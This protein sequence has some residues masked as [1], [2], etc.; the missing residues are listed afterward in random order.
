[1]STYES[2]PDAPVLNMPTRPMYWSLRRELWENRSLYMAPLLVAAVCMFGFVISTI[3]MPHRRRATMLLDPAHRSAA[4]AQPYNA[5]AMML[6]FASFIVA[7]F[8][9]IDALY[10]ERRDRSILFW[11]SLPVSDRTTV[12]AKAIVPM[13]ILPAITFATIVLVQFCMLMWSTLI[14]LPSGQGLTTWSGFNIFEESL[15][16]LYCMIAMALWYAP[17]YG[18]FLLVSGWAKRATFLWAILPIFA[19]GILDQ[20]LFHGTHFAATMKYRL[21][22]FAGEAFDVKPHGQLDSLA[23]ITPGRFLATPGLWVG[24]IVA[25]LFLAAAVRLRRSREPI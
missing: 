9:C 25:A 21:M 6:L 2:Q 19:L 7:V 11:K 18:W 15:I 24:L 23:Q 4:I 22:G 10:G 14:L 20:M 12:F 17:I 1:M 5:V 13:A 8:Y 16:L 3:G